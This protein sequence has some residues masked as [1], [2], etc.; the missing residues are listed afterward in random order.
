LVSADCCVPFS[1]IAA[2]PLVIRVP[3]LS[4]CSCRRHI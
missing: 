2:F 1:D 4:G 3:H